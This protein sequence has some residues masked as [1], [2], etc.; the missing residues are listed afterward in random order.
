[1]TTDLDI[2]RAAHLVIRHHGEDAPIQAAIR[3]DEML[4]NGDL[5]GQVTWK[6]II[7]AIDDLLAVEPPEGEKVH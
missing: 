5:D 1:M 6:R 3:A 4:E 2:Y 7:R